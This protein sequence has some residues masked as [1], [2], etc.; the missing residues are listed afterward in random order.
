MIFKREPAVWLNL[1]ASAVALLSAYVLHLTTDQQ[2][3]LNALAAAGVALAVGIM[4]H[5]SWA[6]LA[7]GLLKAVIMLALAWH[8]HVSAENQ[9]LIFTLASAVLAAFGA[10]GGTQRSVAA[11]H[12]ADRVP[13]P[14]TSTSRR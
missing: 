4:T 5:D 8:L 11:V 13:F 6:P 9:A 3:T 2:G 1:I 7:L 14:V 10:A 12:D